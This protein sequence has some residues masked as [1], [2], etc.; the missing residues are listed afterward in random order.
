MD[1]RAKF[2]ELTT[3]TYPIGTEKAVRNLLPKKLIEDPFGNL[4]WIIGKSD[5]MFCAHLDTVDSGSPGKN[6]DIVH[7]LEG[8]ILKT[9]GNTILGGDDKA[10]VVIMLYMIEKGIPGFY[11]FTHGEEKGCV[12]SSKLSQKLQTKPD[13]IYK[14]IKKIIAFD[15]AGF[16]SII[17]H[18]MTQR[19]ASDA[20]AN[21]LIDELNKSGLK[22]TLDTKGYYCDSAEFADI[23]PECTNISVGYLDQHSKTE[24]QDLDFLEKLAEACCK[25]DWASL[26]V[27]RDPTKIEIIDSYYDSKTR[28]IDDEI[29]EF[30]DYDF[31]PFEINDNKDVEVLYFE[32]DKFNSISDISYLD[33]EII[34]ITLCQKRVEYELDIITKYM[35]E[36]DIS[37]DYAVWDG[38]ILTIEHDRHET[39]LSRNDILKYIP[40]L[41]IN[42]I[43]N[44]KK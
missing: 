39:K 27:E 33:G 42:S 43:K 2:I 5:T 16:S 8:N 1:I 4:Y 24:R 23:I 36:T 32:D 25:V 20:F 10:G 30:D 21:T 35:A 15:R 38:L 14:N 34:D 26:P 9:D 28:R 3:K 41:E 12:G 18:Q 22:Y 31:H 19:S 37:Y 7:V 40:E 17:T 44:L 29:P 11:L 6:L 13:E